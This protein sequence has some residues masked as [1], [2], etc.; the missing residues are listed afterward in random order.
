MMKKNRRA[1]LRIIGRRG[2]GGNDDKEEE[3]DLGGADER[4][5]EGYG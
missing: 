3:A 2:D 4:G 5:K 1:R